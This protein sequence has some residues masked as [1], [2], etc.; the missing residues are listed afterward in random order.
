MA[1]TTRWDGGHASSNNFSEADNWDNGVPAAGDTIEF[2]GTTRL[3]PNNNL[4]ADTSFAAI[5][6]VSGAGAFTIGGNRI[7][8]GGTLTNSD[9][10]TQ[11][12]SLDII[13]DASRTIACTSGPIVISGA[14]SGN[15]GSIDTTAFTKTGAYGL[16][17]SG[18]NT[19]IG[20][21]TV[22]GGTLYAGST[23]AFASQRAN[24]DNT[25]GVTL[26]ITGFDVTLGSIVSGGTT[27]G[28]VVLGSQT[29]TVG[30]DN[31]NQIY[32][33]AISGTGGVTKI[34][35]G[36][37]TFNGVASS[38]TGVTRIQNGTIVVAS[39]VNVGAG[40]SSIGAPT[41]AANGTI[42]LGDGT[43]TGQLAFISASG[44][45]S[46]DRVINLAGT[47]G[48]GSLRNSTVGGA[49]DITFTSDFTATGSGAKTLLL[50]GN[51][52][53]SDGIITGKIVDSAGGATSVE[54]Q[55]INSVWTLSGANT[56]T[57]GT[58]VTT[59]RLAAGSTS[60]FGVGSAVTMATG[61]SA[62]L[63]ITGYNNTIGSITGGSSGG[64]SVTL[65]SATLTI[66]S[67]N[68]SP[69]AYAGAI[70]GSGGNIV[71]TGSGVLT[72]SSASNSFTGTI[73]VSQG[74]LI[75][76]GT[77]SGTGAI[78]VANTATLGGVG[79]F[80]GA[81]TMSAGSTLAP[82]STGVSI[83]TLN[84]AAVT[85]NA[86]S[87]YSVDLN[88][89]TPTF[90]KINSS[91]TVACAGVLTVANIINS[92]VGKVYTIVGA[93]TVSGTF[94]GLPEGYVKVTGGRY[95]KISYLGNN[96]TL[97]DI[98]AARFA[99]HTTGRGF[100]RGVGVGIM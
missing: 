62:I 63:D 49:G 22:S 85:M 33:G 66:G 94:S 58:L 92:A 75:N 8:L 70:S 46:T 68:T 29:L 98:D 50:F 47:T 84:T 16:T 30:N 24:L 69:A 57:G 95:L 76:D 38:Y 96:V 87:T 34:G 48:G 74:T 56:Y 90:D 14:I 35:T 83:G 5:T 73:T 32:T 78:T 71:K 42:H 43:T 64:G 86:T 97:T 99:E 79:T 54:K 93:S 55:G 15:L 9:D 61:V 39:L 53:G 18:N 3:T 6:F 100:M 89:T 37:Q 40:N 27:G 59:G 91:G 1:K 17:L 20:V 52:S 11:T 67:N 19:F 2:G 10:S 45:C 80:A 77:V 28:N 88:G 21:I 4:T 23:T 82:G 65:G 41:T 51:I 31:S 44:S 81:I 25:A 7:T 13:L 72:L 60:A 26:D 12:I 36:F